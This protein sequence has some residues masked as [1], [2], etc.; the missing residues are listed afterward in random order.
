MGSWERRIN[1]AVRAMRP[2]L[3]RSWI[4][5]ADLTKKN[6]KGNCCNSYPNLDGNFVSTIVITHGTH[7]TIKAQV[8]AG[9]P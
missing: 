8:W 9:K 7:R 2:L 3:F 5:N 1:I 6:Q 4:G